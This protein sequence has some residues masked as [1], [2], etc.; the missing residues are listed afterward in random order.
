M[1]FENGA[2]EAMAMSWVPGDVSAIHDHGTDMY[3]GCVK[4]FGI[5]EHSTYVF[6]GVN[7][8]LTALH[9]LAEGDT[10]VVEHGLIHQMANHEGHHMSLHVYAR[11]RADHTR[12]VTDDTRIF[13]P[14]AGRVDVVNGGAFLAGPAHAVSSSTAGLAADFASTVRDRM[15]TAQRVQRAAAAGAPIAG[16]D[17]VGLHA[18]LFASNRTHAHLLAE[19]DGALDAGGHHADSRWWSA[20]HATARR[21]AAHQAEAKAAQQRADSFADYAAMYDALIGRPCL[22]GFMA[23]FIAAFFEA[24]VPEPAAVKM[25]SIGCGT[26]LVEE[27]IVQAHGV[28]P[29][30]LLGFDFSAAQVAEAQKRGLRAQVG[31]CLE[32]GPELYGEH[33]V[34]F[35]GLNVFHYL[36]AE[37]MAE[38]VERTASVLRPGGFFFG[39][40]ITPDHIRWYPNVMYGGAD[41]RVVSLRTPRLVQEG[42]KMYQQSSIVNLDFRA[43]R[44]VLNDAGTHKRH[45]P[46]LLRVRQMFEE[47]F[48]EDVRLFDA[49]SMEPIPRDADTCASTR[50]VV[51]A[52]KTKECAPPPPST[53]AASA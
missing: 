16:E 53:L 24:H 35:A 1:I 29:S 9:A 51:I 18:A 37:R 45:L 26:G 7:L 27:H 32:M 39:D 17:V 15:F 41:K 20:L 25:L 4:V 43:D 36:P 52:R 33:D 11:P 5:F 46:A 44:A 14:R 47:A 28:L 6:D 10:V 48:G 3:H 31:D 49:V 40:F 42:G 19:L 2:F 23:R 21:W 22:D 38:A 34:A 50:Y 12:G 30:N 13:S 8:R